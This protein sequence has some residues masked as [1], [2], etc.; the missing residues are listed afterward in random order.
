MWAPSSGNWMLFVSLRLKA[1]D[2]LVLRAQP[3]QCKAPQPYTTSWGENHF[4]SQYYL[5][6]NFYLPPF[7]IWSVSVKFSWKGLIIFLIAPES[8]QPF[9][10]SAVMSV[11][12]GSLNTPDDEGGVMSAGRWAG[13]SEETL[14]FLAAT[15]TGK[16]QATILLIKFGVSSTEQGWSHF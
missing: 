14:S 15:L 10:Q 9:L 8:T 3:H 11:A 16:S 6:V 1:G 5:G 2:V 4:P 7:I 13:M 12:S